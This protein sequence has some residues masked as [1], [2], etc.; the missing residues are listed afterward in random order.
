MK[1]IPH[2]PCKFNKRLHLPEICKRLTKGNVLCFSEFKLEFSCSIDGWVFDAGP[3][4]LYL[5][6][7]GCSSRGISLGCVQLNLTRC[8][9]YLH[10]CSALHLV[11]TT[12]VL[13]WLHNIHVALMTPL[14]QQHLLVESP[15]RLWSP[16]H[17][18][19]RLRYLVGTS[20]ASPFLV[21]ICFTAQLTIQPGYMTC[22]WECAGNYS[23]H[24]VMPNLPSRKGTFGN[25]NPVHRWNGI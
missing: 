4:I 6:N 1:K 16:Q 8:S 25:A 18:C 13:K 12:W 5:S 10:A 11:G 17:G 20:A 15:E 23:F 14:N 9:A 2:K 7:C 19:W 22:N 3:Q 24:S 21:G